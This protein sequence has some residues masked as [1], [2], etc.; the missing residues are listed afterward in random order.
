MKN[1]P[2]FVVITGPMF[3]SKTT[4]LFTHVQRY[5]HKH[6]NYVIF[7]PSM[8]DRYKLDDIETHDGLR[9]P[10]VRIK[11]GSDILEF[12]FEGDENYDMIAVDEAFMIPDVAKALILLFSHGYNVFV[13]SL[14]LSATG[15]TF[16][17]VK[18]MLPWATRIEKLTAVCSV[19]GADAHYTYKRSGFDSN[20]EIEVGGAEEYEPRCWSCHPSIN[21]R[22]K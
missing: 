1:N 17:E 14:N 11:T 20:V 16:K 21:E 9:M 13:S 22:D 8:D 15:K 10:A 6:Q 12:I 5:V 3:A 19:C 4:S 7:K 2:E 18:E